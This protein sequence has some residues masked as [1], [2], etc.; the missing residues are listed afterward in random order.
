MQRLILLALGLVSAGLITLVGYRMLARKPQ[1]PNQ[2]DVRFMQ[3]ARQAVDKFSEVKTRPVTPQEFSQAVRRVATKDLD[4]VPADEQGSLVACLE[5]FF[6]CY[7]SGSFEDYKTFRLRPPFEVGSH[8]VAAATKAAAQSGASLK[9]DDDILRFAWEKYN[10][11]NRVWEFNLESIRLA[12]VERNDLG[13]ELRKASASK[14][15]E[16]GAS[17]CWEGAVAYHP[18]PPSLLKKDGK[19]RFLTLEVFVRFAPQKVGPATPLVL[20]CYWDPTRKEWMPQALCRMFNA[21]DY[22]TLF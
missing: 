14:W 17:S 2:P 21:G 19:L 3:A 22:R 4:K 8:L 6:S 20:M 15:P 13:Y 9:T 12:V 1:A 7:V 5:R 18:D 11:T 10:G 16:L